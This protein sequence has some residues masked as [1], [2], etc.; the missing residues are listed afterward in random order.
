VVFGCPVRSDGAPT[1]ALGRRLG[2]ALELAVGDPAA[3]LIVSG[4]AVIG[5]CEAQAMARWLEERGV[6]A[7]R[8][9]REEAARDTLENAV[10]S[11]A[12]V[13]QLGAREVSLV[14]ERYHIARSAALLRAALRRSGVPARV[15]PAPAPDGLVG[16]GRVERLVRERVKML[17]D[18]VRHAMGRSGSAPVGP[19]GA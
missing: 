16:L 10:F 18:R 17:T 13:R 12:L 7:A 9:L 8:I 5:P 2:R 15:H 6:D 11:A 19:L 1:S 4:G 3:T 14:T